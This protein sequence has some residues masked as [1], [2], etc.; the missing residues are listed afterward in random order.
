MKVHYDDDPRDERDH[1]RPIY[2]ELDLSY[3]NIP[4]SFTIDEVYLTTTAEYE[5]IYNYMLTGKSDKNIGIGGGGNS[6]WGLG[7]K[8]NKIIM[9]YSIS[10]MGEGS[11]FK[12]ELPCEPY[13]DIFRRLVDLSMCIDK[14]ERYQQ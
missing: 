11:S 13:V 2:V 12:I 7:F 1:Y 9:E 14:K 5:D 4:I 8:D 6:Y 10:G 3:D